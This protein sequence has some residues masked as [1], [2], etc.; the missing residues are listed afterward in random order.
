M[1]RSFLLLLGLPLALAAGL[2]AG[3]LRA[4][5]PA[6]SLA[7]DARGLTAA[8]PRAEADPFAQFLDLTD[9]DGGALAADYRALDEAHGRAATR[10]DELRRRLAAA[11]TTTTALFEAW[12]ADLNQYRD[13]ALRAESED[14]LRTAR[15]HADSALTAMRASVVYADSAVAAL[16]DR[17]LAAKH[18]LGA[19]AAGALAAPARTLD[20]DARTLHDEVART[21]APAPPPA[22][23]NPADSS[24]LR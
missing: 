4:A 8:S 3:A 11:E 21:L 6:D 23:P 17:T 14:A 5:S 19:E 1:R 10:A 22:T 9:F 2:A 7:T 18:R 13:P 24:T 15:T 16:R 20:A 12:A